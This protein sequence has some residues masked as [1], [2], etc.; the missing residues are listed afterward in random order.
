MKGYKEYLELVLTNDMRKAYNELV[1]G[2]LVK[3]KLDKFKVTVLFDQKDDKDDTLERTCRR[4]GPEECDLDCQ[5][6]FDFPIAP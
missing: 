4:G 5:Q 3:E 6:Y 2:C 1:G